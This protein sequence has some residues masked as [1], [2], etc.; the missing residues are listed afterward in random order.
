MMGWIGPH[1]INTWIWNFLRTVLNFNVVCV[2]IDHIV[3]HKKKYIYFFEETM[4]YN[5]E[6]LS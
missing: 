2:Y 1:L 6:F 4:Y 5:L 3:H